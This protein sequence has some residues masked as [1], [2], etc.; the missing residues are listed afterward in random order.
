MAQN[1][2]GCDREQELLLPPS[3]REW[4]PEEHLAWFVLDAVAELDLGAFYASYRDDG[5]GRAAHDPAM[6]VALFIYAYAT[7]Q[8]SSA[9][10]ERRCRDDVAFRVISA[11]QA[12]DHATIARFRV[13]H[14]RALSEL[15]G[16][17]LGLCA[18]AGLIRVGVVA[19]D[20]TKVHANASER[21][22]RDYGQIAREILEQAAEID[23]AED[24]QFGER[25][26]DELPPALATREGRQRWL[27]DAQRAA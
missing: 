23:A 14:E 8:R 11:N 2:I 6:M 19:V 17:V 16:Q 1:F 10:I 18:D 26:G 13:R 4:L 24:E 7:A 20:G 3:L 25:R 12:P 27:R 15:F 22:T 21:A 9:S 5:W